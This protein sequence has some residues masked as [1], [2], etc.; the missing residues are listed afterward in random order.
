MS[1]DGILNVC[2][3]EGKTSFSVIARLRKISGQRRIGHSGTLDPIA[4]GVLPILF[5]QAARI[6]ALMTD[7]D[8]TYVA[9]IE[10][11]MTTDTYDRTGTV[12]T[13]SGA[14]DVP[15]KDV[16]KALATFRGIIVQIP[17]I[18]SAIKYKGKHYYQLARSG[19][20]VNP[21]PRSVR[22]IN[23]RLIEYNSPSILI[24]LECSKGTYVRSLA[25]DLGQIL[26]CGAYIKN[27]TRTKCGVF[28]IENS[29]TMSEVEDAFKNEVWEKLMT[30]V[31][32][33]LPGLRKVTLSDK[34]GKWI[35]SGGYLD[36]D[37]GPSSPEELLRAYNEDDKLITILEFDKGQNRWHSKITFKL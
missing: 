21:E 27:L 23:L 17:P 6:T 20:A 9:E 37:G 36:L 14:V 8:K 13:R 10:L 26:G 16:E 25:F 2:K 30:P 12:L 18:F 1:I 5:G 35:T 7:T 15:L 34:D 33:P 22:I 29:Y 31:D 4:T 11:G 24:E 19:V 3:P 32:Y 28:K